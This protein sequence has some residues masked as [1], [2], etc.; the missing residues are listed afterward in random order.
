MISLILSTFFNFFFLLTPFFVLL[1][2]LDVCKDKN[3]KEQ[4]KIAFKTTGY[5]LGICLVILF[6]GNTIF[7]T[8]GI[9]LIAFQIGSGLILLLS[10]IGMMKDN[11]V[12]TRVVSSNSDPSL[13][14][15]T[16]PITVGPGTVGALFILGS[17]VTSLP[18][19]SLICSILGIFLAVFAIWLLLFYSNFILK[20][21]GYNGLK[22]LSKLTGLFLSILAIQSILNGITS[23]IGTLK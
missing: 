16:L 8:L 17:K 9:T 2:F 5:I 13:I 22:V 10:G 4:K 1:L 11:T 20:I 23:F 15:L 6:F 14:P 7:S 21:I 12:K 18:V 3:I 19:S